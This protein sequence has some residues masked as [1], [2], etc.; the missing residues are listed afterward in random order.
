MDSRLHHI[1]TFVLGSM[2]GIAGFFMPLKSAFVAL[3]CVVVVDFITGIWASRIKKIS[4]SSRRMR[5]SVRKMI[6]YFGLIS[7]LFIIEKEFDFDF[8]SYRFIGGFICFVELISI[9]ENTAVI[10]GN[11][12]FLSIIKLIRGKAQG[13]YGEIIDEILKEKNE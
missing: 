2:S 6:G 8:G 1:F 4:I 9:L 13:T 5:L 12:I 3:L 11:K 7:L 10:S